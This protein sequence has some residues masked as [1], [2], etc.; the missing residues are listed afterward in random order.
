MHV[1]RCTVSSPRLYS[2]PKPPAPRVS[3]NVP[4]FVLEEPTYTSLGMSK[5]AEVLSKATMGTL[6]AL[7]QAAP[8]LALSIGAATGHFLL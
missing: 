8:G 6:A 4:L 5:L 1:S 2:A 7:L 3:N